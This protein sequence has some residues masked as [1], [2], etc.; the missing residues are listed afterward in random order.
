MGASEAYNP[1][2][3]TPASRHVQRTGARR[4]QPVAR[5]NERK[6]LF[7]RQLTGCVDDI[8]VGMQHIIQRL[9]LR[10]GPCPK[11]PAP[12][13]QKCF[14]GCHIP[15]DGPIGRTVVGTCVQDDVAAARHYPFHRTLHSGPATVDHGCA[16]SAPMLARLLN[17]PE[18]GGPVGSILAPGAWRGRGPCRATLRA[19]GRFPRSV[20]VDVHEPSKWP[21]AL[22][23]HANGNA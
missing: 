19:S 10:C 17:H 13:F 3:G 11:D 21:A 9:P 18:H 6:Q 5:G 1:V 20:V 22:G 2:H 12:N 4:N 14:H 23:P 8:L 15:F 16:R 7:Q